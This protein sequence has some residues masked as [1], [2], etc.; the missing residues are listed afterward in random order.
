MPFSPSMNVMA[1]LQDPV[2]AKPRSSVIIPVEARSR[3]MSIASSP[4]L[5][6]T[7]GSSTV[8]PSNAR[9][10]PV[11]LLVMVSLDMLRS[12]EADAARARSPAVDPSFGS[13][14]E[15]FDSRD[16]WYRAPRHS[17]GSRALERS[18]QFSQEAYPAA[19]ATSRAEAH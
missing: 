16:V 14:P 19:G 5:P 8:L 13:D 17:S 10:A 11:W 15:S 7:T 6:R 4:S 2:F 9:L 3:S 18:I 1:L 12:S